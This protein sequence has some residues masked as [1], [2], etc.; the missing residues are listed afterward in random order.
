MM[1]IAVGQVESLSNGLGDCEGLDTGVTRAERQEREDAM[2]AVDREDWMDWKGS[3][4]W[5][6][7]NVWMYVGKYGLDR[8]ECWNGGWW[9]WRMRS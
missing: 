1:M 5:R 3:N 4:G 2:D 8:I 7:S 6:G 9:M